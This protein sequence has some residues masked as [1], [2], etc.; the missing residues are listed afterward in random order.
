VTGLGCGLEVRDELLVGAG[1]GVG[2]LV[3]LLDEEL[4]QPATATH[5]H[6]RAMAPRRLV[7]IACLS[8]SHLPADYTANKR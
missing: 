7:T 3:V 6:N 2:V 8:V 4:E 1:T 5:R